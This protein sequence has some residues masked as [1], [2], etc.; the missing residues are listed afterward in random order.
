[1]AILNSL[2]GALGGVKDRAIAACVKVFLNQKIEKFGSIVDLQIDSAH[3]TICAHLALK[4]ETSAIAI[5]SC[6]YELI[7]EN[8]Q[9]YISFTGFHASRE[10]IENLLREYVAGKRFRLPDVASMAL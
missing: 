7:Q 9:T 1:M 4:G 5:N 8:G 2:A 6:E 10:W 3:R